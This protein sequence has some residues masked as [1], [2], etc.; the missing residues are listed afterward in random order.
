[1]RVTAV[2]FVTF[3]FLAFS[4]RTT[5]P[6][7]QSD[8]SQAL[9]VTAPAIDPDAPL[10]VNSKVKIGKLENGL[11]YYIRQNDR[12]DDRAELRLVVDAG[13]VLEDDDQRGLAHFVEH[14]AFNGTENYP[15]QEL[16][17]Y[18]ELTGTR[19]G[20]DLNAYTSLD[21]T[22]YMLSVRTDSVE[23]L[24]TGIEI[25]REWA[26]L[27]VFEPEEVEKERGVVV[28]EWRLGRGAQ[29]RIFD[30]QLPVL[31]K[32]SKYAERL[33]IGKKE[34]LESADRQTMVRFYEDWYRP[35]LMAVVVVGDIDVDRIET[36]IRT[37]FSE[38]PKK[39]DPR[40]R[41]SFGAPDHTDP[42][43]AV[44]TDPEAP[45]SRVRVVYKFPREDANS[46]KA[47]RRLLVE[48]LYNGM[49][50][51]RLFELTQSPTP[52]YVA[53]GSGRGSFTRNPD[54]YNLI[55]IAQEGQ[56]PHSMAALLTEA[57][58]VR[59]FGFTPT[60]LERQ[61]QNLLR[62]YETA[63]NERDKTESGRLVNELVNHFLEDE[64]IP[65][66][67]F[68]FETAKRLVPGITVEEV[69]DLAKKLITD[70]NRVVLA[71]GPERDGLEYPDDEA[72]LA[73]FESV[74]ASELEPYEDKVLDEP[75]M[76]E[77]PTAG[78][79]VSEKTDESVGVT[80]LRLSNGIR[81]LLKPTTFKNDEIL[82]A[83]E[84]PGGTSLV[85]DDEYV[86]ASYASSMI[87]MGG[88]GAFGPIELDKKLAGKVVSVSPFVGELSEGLRGS[89]TPED[90]ETLFQLVHLYVTQPRVDSTAYLSYVE[91]IGSLL[92]SFKLDPARAYSD[93]IQV[94]MAQYHPRRKPLS[95]ETLDQ[96]DL[97]KSFEIYRDRFEDIGDFTFFLVGAFEMEDI[98]PLITRY[99][100]S[101]PAGGREET[102]RDV[103]VRPPKGLVEKAVRR[104]IEPKSR[105]YLH[106]SG[107]HPWSN[108]DRR[109]ISVVD[110]VLNTRLRE[111]LR[112]DLGGTYGVSV[113]GSLQRRPTERFSFVINFGCDP[114]RV[115]ELT[116]K[117]YAVV[118]SLVTVGT[119][120]SYLQRSRETTMTGHRV[121]LEENGSWLR[122]L[123]FYDLNGLP[124]SE[125]P[126]GVV[127]FYDE[128]T[129][130]EVREAARTFLTGD[131]RAR[132]VLYP[133]GWTEN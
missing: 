78:S 14:M 54:F 64:P 118:D 122:W 76:A 57:E 31:L 29:S 109:L 7:T 26:G 120:E 38:I 5:R 123:Q 99:L 133:E 24:D 79:I 96:M 127:R 101:L 90:L 55:A 129:L 72:L 130:E 69:N 63:F 58:R 98:K 19:F 111:V 46:I 87:N 128:L 49:F 30:Q 17:D 84:S 11:T 124:F 48:Q 53:A 65:G 112:E 35:D 108:R 67:E 110:D 40:E 56:I 103:G 43:V 95:R 23:Q 37:L 41:A 12:P 131:N 114:E 80:E 6:D 102:W 32:G 104:G 74:A 25:L 60:E 81:V 45:Y 4:C 16:I 126:D 85:G 2:L 119:D 68:E 71:D 94:T 117:V 113:S 28:E 42:L 83:A 121:G 33:P 39:Q 77:L 52:P 107:E 59:R 86:P 21:E 18:L 100:A 13:S 8:V 73:V 20:P 91:R 82:L 50:N 34:T 116:D 10:P 44:V 47:F 9:T 61:K 88:L 106:W 51:E 22:V 75:L 62:G 3:S 66:V 132:I 97:Q 15:K 92:E 1:M 36:M 115:D 70:T 89:A 125:I 27:V 105:V 93:T